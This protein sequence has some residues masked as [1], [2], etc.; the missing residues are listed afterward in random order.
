M[1]LAVILAANEGQ[2]RRVH[3]EIGAFRGWESEGKCGKAVRTGIG[4]ERGGSVSNH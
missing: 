1:S 4:E 3:E 2:R